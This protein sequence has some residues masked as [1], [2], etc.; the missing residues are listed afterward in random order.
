MLRVIKILIVFFITL[1]GEELK[2]YNES[3][4]SWKTA[5]EFGN[6]EA[7]FNLA[8]VAMKDT[9]NPNNIETAIKLYQFSSDKGDLESSYNLGVIYFNEKKYQDYKKAVEFFQKAHE[10]DEAKFALGVCYNFGLG[11]NLDKTKALEYFQKAITTSAGAQ[12]IVSQEYLK[13]GDIK[14]AVPLLIS[15]SEAENPVAMYN[16]GRL[17]DDENLEYHNH[18]E[19][20]RLYKRAAKLG[21]KEAQFN[22]GYIYLIG[23][24]LDQDN[25]KAA[26]WLDKAITQGDTQA[27]KLFSEYNLSL[28]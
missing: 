24:G 11:V 8:L 1:Y 15:A 13:K 18:I 12:N 5:L 23:D 2:D 17:Y 28:F 26:Y 6:K 16:L 22:L 19:A 9:Q 3:I 14:S 20:I 21:V 10:L 25:K 4:K 27:K 7:S